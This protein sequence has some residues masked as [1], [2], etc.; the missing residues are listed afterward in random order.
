MS[1]TT[2]LTLTEMREQYDA[3]KN[4]LANT[5]SRADL[6]AKRLQNTAVRTGAAYLATKYVK[7]TRAQGQ[8]PFA[9]FGLTPLQTL[10]AAGIIVGEFLDGETGE[11]VSA[12][13]EGM[14]CAAAAELA[15]S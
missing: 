4:R 10:A 7:T 14:L 15:N 5:R 11:V 9:V 8:T 1:T 13:G 3:M 2:G 6:A 12:A